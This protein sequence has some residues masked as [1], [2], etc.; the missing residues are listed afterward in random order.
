MADIGY[1]T[2][3]IIPTM[4]GNWKRLFSDIDA[5]ATI[6]GATAGREYGRALI[7]DLAAATG[8]ADPYAKITDKASESGRSAGSKFAASL[9]ES[10][11]AHT[12]DMTS[13][14]FGAMFGA[15]ALYGLAYSAGQGI[16][17]A[18]KT[19]INSAGDLQS[20]QLSFE[21][22]LGKG[23]GDA[24]NKQLQALADSTS[25]DDT[26][27]M[28]TGKALLGAGIPAK[29]LLG[30]MTALGDGM[31]AFSANTADSNT[32]FL[33]FS[34]IMARGTVDLQD[35][36]QIQ[37]AI[38]SAN[39]ELAKSLGVPT[40]ALGDLI[41]SGKLAANDVMPKFLAQ[42]HY[43]GSLTKQA[44]TINGA[45]ANMGDTIK[46]KLGEDLLPILSK[47]TPY[48]APVTDGIGKFLGWLSKLGGVA[49]GGVKD[50]FDSLGK[51]SDAMKTI[52]KAF[53]DST[54]SGVKKFADLMGKAGDA[55]GTVFDFVAKHPT[56]VKS[57]LKAVA[58]V[59]AAFLGLT[60]IE[61]I[62]DALNPF[63]LLL[64]GITAVVAGA[65][66]LNEV[67]QKKFGGWR[68]LFSDIGSWFKNIWSDVSGWF[69]GLWNTV[70]SGVEGAWNGIA[71]FFSGL[72][73]GIKS[74]ATTAWNDTVSWIGGIPGR[75]TSTLGDLGSLL[76]SAG[77]SII[78]G[79]L[80]GLKDKYEDVKSF[81]GGIAQWIK[82]HKGPISYDAVLLTPA[83]KAI[84]D[85]LHAGLSAG[86]PVV[87]GIIADVNRALA[88]TGRNV[89]VAGPNANG[90]A[91]AANGAGIARTTI[92]QTFVTNNPVARDPMQSIREGAQT[93]RTH[94]VL[95][96][97]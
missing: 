89:Y 55:L 93:A 63:T 73:S 26:T 65:I 43:G 54:T 36:R 22:L 17:S 44:T 64:L 35:F 27:V 75:I 2:L 79:L 70:T 86:F 21:T 60:V 90:A 84:M 47:I 10:I 80:S 5:E 15:Q 3:S 85:G 24:I 91:V 48:L 19:G 96:V 29:S 18:I 33:G 9:S 1:A 57:I 32:A 7:S 11:K 71:G 67:V 16:M 12:S 42:L 74:G 51:H 37:M 45:L 4:E 53:D 49:L 77:S 8:N 61:A 38:P 28:N 30:D 76:Y 25:F 82:D 59:T 34:Q 62:M 68:A 56:A 69:V 72:W 94:M 83:G 39:Q 46:T 97:V 13:S 20:N 31:A 58:D 78:G 88:T 6:E 50:F 14:V 52:G 23:Q 81:V 40:S 41:S 87:K 66:Y 95:G 92:N